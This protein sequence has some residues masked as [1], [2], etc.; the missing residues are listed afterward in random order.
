MISWA[1]FAFLFLDQIV[2]HVHRVFDR[3]QILGDQFLAALGLL[4]R[5]HWSTRKPKLMGHLHQYGTEF[6]IVD[7]AHDL[8]LE[9]LM[10]LKEVTDQGRLQY[11]P[12]SRL[13]QDRGALPVFSSA[14]ASSLASNSADLHPSSCKTHVLPSG[15]LKVAYVTPLSG[16][17]SLL[18][19]T[20]RPTSASRAW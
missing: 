11:E 4:I 15:S 18:T 16:P 6:L 17:I 10:L 12:G 13:R 9:H 8:S 14:S 5:G 3:G 20:P 2:I 19:Y 1:L 7:D